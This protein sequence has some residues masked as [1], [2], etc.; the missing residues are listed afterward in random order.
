MN[1]PT[2]RPLKT[3]KTVRGEPFIGVSQ[4]TRR[5][6]DFIN[7]AFDT[8]NV[9]VLWGEPG[10]GKTALINAV[11]EKRG[12]LL[13]TLIGSTMDPTDVGGLPKLMDLDNGDTLTQYTKT[14]W[15]YEIE[16]Y[17]HSHPAGACLFIDE[18]TTASPPV[19]AALLTFIQDRR[20]GKYVLPDNVLLIAAANPPSVAADGWQLAPPT[21][22]RFTHIDYKPSIEDWFAGMKLAWNKEVSERE[23]YIRGLVVAFLT[24]H[25]DLIQKLPEDSDEAG[26]AWPSM[27]S[28]DNTAR[29][30]G[31][32]QDAALANMVT[33]AGVGEEAGSEFI[34][35]MNQ[36]AIPQYDDVM[37]NP[38]AVPWG[39]LRGD[40]LYVVLSTVI[41]NVSYDNFQRS[42]K[43][44]R[45]AKN[46]QKNDVLASLLLPFKSHAMEAFSSN[47]TDPVAAREQVG[48]LA[49]ELLGTLQ[50]S[51]YN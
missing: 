43:V 19:Q 16:E 15:F 24:S 14:D 25:R 28:W 32:T 31:A 22:N 30:L 12:M 40:E 51:L 49:V 35:W 13:R 38:D 39:S 18:L 46:A 33:L 10:V 2:R 50:G 1:I 26:R 20:V 23:T 27:R 5:Y 21:A 7:I 36:L 4:Q 34:S 47:N 44:F 42:L 17:A 3:L 8:K 37:E 29:M 9:P 48:E 41:D 6:L 11:T 45:S